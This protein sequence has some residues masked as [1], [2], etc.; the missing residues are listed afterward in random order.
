MVRRILFG[1]VIG[2]LLLVAVVLFNT[3][4][5][6]S[7]Q[8]T[9]QYIPAPDVPAQALKH[10]TEA[11]RYQTIS[12]EDTIKTDTSAFL[13]FHQFLRE[14]YPLSHEKLEPELVAGLSLLYRWE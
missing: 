5:F 2:L 13:A 6:R 4:T 14:A 7:V 3:F 11:I 1:V 10:L 8:S 9:V 12:S